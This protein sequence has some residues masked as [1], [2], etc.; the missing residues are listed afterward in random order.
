MK[1]G[2]I[3]YL[4]FIAGIFLLTTVLLGNDKGIK[5]GDKKKSK[6]HILDD[7]LAQAKAAR[8]NK[9]ES[10]NSGKPQGKVYSDTKTG[11]VTSASDEDQSNILDHLLNKAMRE[12]VSRDS[13]QAAGPYKTNTRGDHLTR[14][15]QHLWKSEYSVGR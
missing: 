8:E 4:N 9:V 15:T 2:A 11:T 10:E 14:E 12:K 7:L 13:E 5:D 6:K 3:I 1:S